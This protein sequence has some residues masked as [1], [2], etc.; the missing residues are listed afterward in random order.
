MLAFLADTSL[1]VV[2][3]YLLVRGPVLDCLFRDELTVRQSLTIGFTLGLVGLLEALFPDARFSYA[4][5]TL[6]VT[7]AAIAGGLGTGLVA[8][9]VV[10]LGVL[11]FQVPVYVVGTVLA[12][13]VSAGLGRAV[14]RART[15]EGRV[16]G[17]FF[18]GALAQFSRLVIHTLVTGSVFD[19]TLRKWSTVPINGF[20]IVLLVLVVT[21][22]QQR[23]D[24][25]RHR[26]DS[27]RAR[28]AALQAQ[29][30]AARARMHPH[31]LFNTL[32]AIAEMC[33]T[34]PD[35]AEVATLKLSALMRKALAVGSGASVPLSEELET[36]RTYLDIERDRLGARLSVV[37]DVPQQLP[38][39]AV[40]PFS[41]QPIVENAV[42]HGIA[43]RDA[44]GAVRVRVRAR[45]GHI[46]ICVSDD[47][48]GMPEAV[49]RSLQSQEE[50]PQHGLAMV[51]CQLGLIYG[52]FG[53]LRIMSKPGRGTVVAFR[54]PLALPARGKSGGSS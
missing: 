8:A 13:F 26:L 40:P 35:R 37:W 6:F 48:V 9:A 25:E 50:Q 36:V 7:F 46:A 15:I 33:V 12:V 32:N 51:Q 39:V 19:W 44:P 23:A 43:P 24:S 14:R 47:G 21:D 3:A 5:H 53:R 1:L 4:T 22:A 16:V 41:I 52:R 45:Q 49:R 30:A 42:V 20:G 29:L 17:G 18:V 54:A 31:F 10:S 38:S 34:C 27:E 11:A 28:A 2:V